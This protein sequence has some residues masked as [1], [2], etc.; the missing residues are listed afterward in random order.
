MNPPDLLWT[1]YN[2]G[3]KDVRHQL[4][5]FRGSKGDVKDSYRRVILN[6]LEILATLCREVHQQMIS[7]IE[8]EVS[9][10]LNNPSVG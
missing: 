8:R 6:K 2:E 1:A 10:L 7:T 4:V 9:V 5:F 3:L